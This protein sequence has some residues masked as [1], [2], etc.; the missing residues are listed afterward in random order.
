MI[1]KRW[2]I[3]T[4]IILLAGLIWF[5]LRPPPVEIACLLPRRTALLVELKDIRSGYS[6][7]DS[8]PFWKELTATSLWKRGKIEER[9]R[10]FMNALLR[11]SGI[12]LDRDRLL[13]LI[14]RDLGLALISGKKG[15]GSPTLLIVTRVDW[16]TRA[17]EFFSRHFK[18]S[19]APRNYE[20][21][22]GTRIFYSDPSGSFPFYISGAFRGGYLLITVSSGEDEVIREVLDHPGSAG[23]DLASLPGFI[24]FQKDNALSFPGVQFYLRARPLGRVFRRLLGAVS[25]S[26]NEELAAPWR[27]SIRKL[28]SRLTGIVSS[29]GGRLQLNDGLSGRLWS[30]P[31]LVWLRKEYGPELL[32]LW[33][34]GP[35]GFRDRDYLP[36][37]TLF[38]LNFR[39][40]PVL[41]GRRFRRELE[42][43]SSQP[44]L[45][46]KLEVWEEKSG[47]RLSRDF[48]PWMGEENTAAL[49]GFDWESL[50]PLPQAAG[51]IQ[52]KAE[53]AAARFLDQLTAYLAAATGVSP[54]RMKYAGHPMTIFP[55]LFLS[56][57]WVRI[58]DFLVIATSRN[59]LRMVVDTKLEKV[60]KLASRP[61]F[62]KVFARLGG[63]ANQ[64]LYL[65]TSRLVESALKLGDWYRARSARRSS[66]EQFYREEVVPLLRVLGKTGSIAVRGRRQ[67]GVA[68]CDFFWYI[69]GLA[70]N[71]LN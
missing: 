15:G 34:M 38:C 13:S 33:R 26:G 35:A 37:R 55:Y 66:R 12:T 40:D 67:D 53:P 23:G 58:D 16:R 27:D 11:E 30:E 8:S 54:R 19:A 9:W 22:G 57:G 68:I 65:D 5:L 28:T 39:T 24:R 56:P 61:A 64:D 7:L 25:I 47:L 71:K 36:A 3:L 70:S 42:A 4:P 32:P 63:A 41:L 62:Q 44:G 31:D 52:I 69:P 17:L 2:V 6:R 14:G 51:F 1:K 59:I 20:E 18:T 50:L 45:I 48:L 29:G 10:E 21:Y 49:I 43:L 46:R 60:P